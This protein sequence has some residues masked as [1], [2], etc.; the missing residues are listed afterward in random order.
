MTTSIINSWEDLDISPEL[1]R[2][3]YNYGFEKP[4]PIQSKAIAPILENKSMIAQAQSGTGKT[5]TFTIGALTRINFDISEEQVIILAP[6]RE[7]AKQIEDVVLQLGCFITPLRTKLLIG[8]NSMKQDIHSLHNTKPQVII[9]CP[10]RILDFIQ[11]KYINIQSIK[12]V[13]LD[14]ADELLS[15]GFQEQIHQIITYVT[16]STQ[17]LLFSATI[18]THLYPIAHKLFIEPPVE[19]LVK[20]EELTLEGIKQYYVALYNDEEK[21]ETLKDL[22]S[23]ICVSQCIIYCNSVRRVVNLH[24]RLSQDGFS[25]S[26]IHGEMDKLDRT[27]SFNDFRTGSTRILI[28]SNI[29]ARGIDIQQ[30]GI[31]INYDIPQDVSSYLHRIGRSGRWGRKGTGINFIT[32]FDINKIKEIEKYY[33]TEIAELPNNFIIR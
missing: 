31:I 15:S 10:G 5:A 9:G 18:P 28:S 12:L 24:H 14:E 27:K 32:K 4:S 1:L 16:T 6:T 21:F 7:L 22:Y 20:Q 13:I 2:G 30:V 19:I 33:D 11:H 17:I 3:I 26:C 25:V 8:G 23:S 29:T